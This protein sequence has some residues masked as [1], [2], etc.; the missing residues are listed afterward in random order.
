MKEFTNRLA[1]NAG[2]LLAF[3][4]LL[5]AVL[6]AVC[7]IKYI[8]R[9]RT[10]KNGQIREARRLYSFLSDNPFQVYILVRGADAFPLF[11]SDNVE[12]IFGLE[13]NDICTDVF[14]FV[15]CMEEEEIGNLKE[16]FRGWDRK[17]P[18]EADFSYVNR[19]TESRGDAFLRVGY[20]ED[21]DIYTIVMEDIS[22][23]KATENRLREELSRARAENDAKTEFL[24]EM[25]H[26][27]RTPMNGILGLL[28]LAKMEISNTEAV[29]EYL[30]KTQNLARFLLHL[31]HDILDLTRI[32]SGKIELQ[33]ESF[34]LIAVAQKMRTMFQKTIEEKELHF[35]LR[36]E[37][38]DVRRVIGDE[39]RLSQVVINFLSNAVKFTDPGGSVILTFRQM[40]KIDNHLRLM[41]Q[42]R[43]TGKG[44][45]PEFLSHIFRPFEQESSMIA[46]KYGGSGLGMSIADNLIRQMGGQIVID[47][48][49]GKGSDF[50][51]FLSLPVAETEQTG[52]AGEGS[53]EL[54]QDAGTTNEEEEL[55]YLKN[56]HVL[57]A[58][59]NDINARI[60]MAILEKAGVRTD[61]VLNG[62]QAVEIFKNSEE[63]FYDVILMDIQMP[64]MD[65]WEAT[66]QIRELDRK[67]ARLIP[68]YALSANSYVEDQRRSLAAGMDDHIAKPIDFNVLKKKMGAAIRNARNAWNAVRTNDMGVTAEKQGEY[69]E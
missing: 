49:V 62:R 33:Q 59:D 1:D 64:E 48:E 13:K 54:R 55:R 44:I 53:H 19:R 67:D 26:E 56:A 12:K 40:E 22:R 21:E 39:M 37:G 16:L 45:E 7:L 52:T 24:S 10:E 31:I 14:A 5:A 35:E 2:T 18:L 66:R 20:A 58:E 32:E 11:V 42:V 69:G 4:V 47:S 9:K 30:D 27:I 34:D 60:T 25:S 50:T 61:R 6:A 8:F 28:E 57:L 51:V 68:V 15:R 17:Q 65:G 38:F 23:R 36:V 29:Q 63:G 41:I 46:K 43:D 3:F